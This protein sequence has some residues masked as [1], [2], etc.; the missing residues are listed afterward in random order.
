MSLILHYIYSL[1]KSGSLCCVCFSVFKKYLQKIPLPVY[2][3]WVL[4]PF[5]LYKE[6][7]ARYPK[8]PMSVSNKD[9]SDNIYQCIYIS[10]WFFDSGFDCKNS[11]KMATYRPKMSILWHNAVLMELL[12]PDNGYPWQRFKT[13]LKS[14]KPRY[15]R[16]NLSKLIANLKLPSLWDSYSMSI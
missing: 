1:T 10:L 9:T 5:W 2:F 4:G 14:K 11:S 7:D 13:Y 15:R 16:L 3:C 12:N 6:F 8:K